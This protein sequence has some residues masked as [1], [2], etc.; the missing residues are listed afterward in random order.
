MTSNQ[1]KY[2]Q[3][4]ETKRNNMAT[5]AEMTRHNLATEHYTGQQIM[6]QQQAN[7]E[8][9][10]H[11]RVNE[12]FQMSSLSANIGETRRHNI[13]QERNDL[14]KANSAY[15]QSE[16]SL[17]GARAN[18][19]NAMTNAYNATVNAA[20]A[21]VNLMNARTN[22]R[23][24]STNIQAVEVNKTRNDIESAKASEQ[25]RHNLVGELT[26][27]SKMGVDLLTTFAKMRKG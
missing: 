14:I 1:A 13:A 3:N 10:R 15:R 16:A 11:N 12:R 9:A 4:V 8:N 26:T 5:L 24:A 18:K 20:N 6:T 19:Q 2:W 25:A 17:I 27:A 7:F 22:A 23:N 21:R